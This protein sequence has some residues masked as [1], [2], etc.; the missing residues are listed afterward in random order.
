MQY[1][2]YVLVIRVANAIFVLKLRNANGAEAVF[3]LEFA[4]LFK[5]A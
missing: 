1:S 3:G 2:L 4:V 5:G